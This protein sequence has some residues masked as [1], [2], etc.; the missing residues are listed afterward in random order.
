MKWVWFLVLACSAGGQDLFNLRPEEAI[1]AAMRSHRLLASGQARVEAAHGARQQAALRPNPRLFLQTENTRLGGPATPFHFARETDNFAYASQVLEAPGKRESRIELTGELIR[2]REAELDVLRATIAHK[3]AAAYW[4]VAGAERTR[5]VLRHSL[6]NFQQ[7]VQ[8]HRDRVSEGALAEADLIRIELE[9]EQIAVQAQNAEQDAR[10]LR[11]QL[12]AEMGEPEMPGAVLTGDLSDVRPFVSVSPEEALANRRDLQLAR[13][14][15]RHT[16]AG[17][18]VEQLSARPDPE[19]LFGYKRTTGFNT[20]LGGVQISLPLR[21]RNQ[22]AIAASL[23]ETKAAELDRRAAEQSARHQIAAAQSEYQQKFQLVT[24]TLP[25]MRGQ[26][27]DTV[28]IARAV[29]REGAS[30]LLRLLDAER[31]ALQTQLLFI[32]S[33]TDYRLALVN[34]QAATGVLP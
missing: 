21:N 30:D 9:R 6:E 5:D 17:T 12:F 10:R 19:I 29:Y 33:L 18:R 27:E 34:L 7:I 8:Y 20:L 11:V 2:R 32:R 15:I 22:G 25:R 4:A 16:K 1:E 28:Q 24:E 31:I 23:A 14:V 3:V 26:A 13:Q